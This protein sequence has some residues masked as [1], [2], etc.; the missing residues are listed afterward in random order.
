MEHNKH[1]MSGMILG[2]M[3]SQPDI[4]EKLQERAKKAG[5]TVEDL[6]KKKL[7]K[8]NLTQNKAQG[9]LTNKGLEMEEFTDKSEYSPKGSDPTN[10]YDTE[11]WVGLLSKKRINKER[12]KI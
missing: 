6:V 3:L 12:S 7:N 2:Y 5:T 4:Y 1:T 10:M 11:E 8:M 9:I